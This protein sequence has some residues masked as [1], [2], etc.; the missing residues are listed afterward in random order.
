MRHTSFQK[1]P[2]I[3][4]DV[5][6]FVLHSENEAPPTFH[7]TPSPLPTHTKIR[8]Q[9]TQSWSFDFNKWF[10]SIFTIRK[11]SSGKVMFSQACVKNS[12]HGGGVHPP[13]QTPLP[14]WHTPPRQTPPR[15]TPPLGQTHLS[16]PGRRL[17]QRT[18]RILL[19]CILVKVNFTLLKSLRMLLA[20]HGFQLLSNSPSLTNITR[21][22]VLVPEKDS[23]GQ[24]KKT[25]VQKRLPLPDTTKAGPIKVPTALLS[26]VITTLGFRTFCSSNIYKKIQFKIEFIQ[27]STSLVR[28]LPTVPSFFFILWLPVSVSFRLPDDGSADSTAESSDGHADFLCNYSWDFPSHPGVTFSFARYSTIS[29]MQM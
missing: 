27:M 4:G 8:S 12:V 7:I 26:L 1:A 11:R 28:P 17:L 9:Q 3:T 6:T 2:H 15:K 19:E 21:Q 5:F 22:P 16:L 14:L 24:S 13:G 23:D 18:V 20:Q 10:L 29:H 25:L